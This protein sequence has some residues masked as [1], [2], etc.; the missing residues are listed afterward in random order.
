MM[1]GASSVRTAQAARRIVGLAAVAG[2]AL[3]ATIAIFVSALPVVAQD[4]DTGVQLDVP[5]REDNT[6]VV[7]RTQTPEPA[8][9]AEG[10]VRLVAL[11]T[12]D[13]QVIDQGLVWRVFEATGGQ[14][15]K[16]LAERR[17][18]TPVVEL[19]SGNYTINA[20]FGRANL[21]RKIT[22]KPGGPAVEQFVL[23]AGGL[24]VKTLVGT[25][26][27][28][29]NAVSYTIYSDERD[30]FANRSTVMNGA[31]PG[32]IIRLNSGIYHVVSTYGDSNAT[33]SSDVTVEAGKLTEMTLTHRAGK[34]TF[35][36]S[37]ESGGDALPDTQW[38]ITTRT[39]DKIRESVGALPT[40]ILL[41]GDY[42]VTAKS[43]GRIFKKEFKVTDGHME[44]VEVVFGDAVDD[45]AVS[46]P[47]R[48]P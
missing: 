47:A 27:A 46:A 26:P 41:P 34:A 48:S 14:K 3:L 1:Q 19:R 28:A 23:N 33:V 42:T 13:G 4:W 35:K 45:L 9:A 39:G 15:A 22:V 30:Q 38:I 43:A 12:A 36:L 25:Q 10:Q 5:P 24:R 40:H 11:L 16:L 20:A 18:S 32:L 21:T 7:P 2:I 31:K 8:L 29:S 6:T 37:A 44:R 17:E